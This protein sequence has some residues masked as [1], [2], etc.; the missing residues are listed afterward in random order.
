MI[1]PAS[2]SNDQSDNDLGRGESLRAQGRAQESPET[3][4][5]AP[6]LAPELA[7]ILAAWPTLPEAIRRAIVAMIEASQ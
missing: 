6:P 7:A 3:L 5:A 1:P 2:D 4:P